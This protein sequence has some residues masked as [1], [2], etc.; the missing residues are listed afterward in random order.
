MESLTATTTIEIDE[1]RVHLAYADSGPPADPA[2]ITI[3]A[4][5]GTGFSRGE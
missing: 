4:L 1:S 5:H 3:F 2:Y